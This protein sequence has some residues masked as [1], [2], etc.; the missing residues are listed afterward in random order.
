MRG[1]P[2][3]DGS[4]LLL[5]STVVYESRN[6]GRYRIGDSDVLNHWS[7]QRWAQIN[8]GEIICVLEIHL[9]ALSEYSSM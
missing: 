4:G 1:G 9:L 5:I 8:G 2:A 3:A 7:R 6:L